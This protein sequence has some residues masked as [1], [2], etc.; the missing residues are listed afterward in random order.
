MQHAVARLLRIADRDQHAMREQQVERPRPEPAVP[1]DEAVLAD[2]AL[3]RRDARHE[4]DVL[5]VVARER[6]N[7]TGLR[8]SS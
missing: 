8:W 5:P 6:A 1:A 7:M 2:R 3:E 4:Q